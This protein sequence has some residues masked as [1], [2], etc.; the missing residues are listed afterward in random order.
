MTDPRRN[1]EIFLRSV[2]GFTDKQGAK[3]SH[4]RPIRLG[5]I[6]YDYVPE[7]FLGGINPRILFDGENTVSNKRYAVMAPYY[8]LAGD[9]V[10]LLPIGN[11]YL[12][13]GPVSSQAIPPDVQYYT[14]DG[15]WT[16]PAGARTI[17]V[18]V[19]AAGGGGGGCPNAGSGEGAV[20]GG[21]GGGGYA[22]SWLTAN[23]VS[24]SEAV[25]VGTGGA[26]GTGADDG[27]AGSSSSFGSHVSAN[28]GGGGTQGTA[29]STR[30][31]RAGGSG[32]TGSAG[33]L[34]IQGGDGFNGYTHGGEITYS[35]AGG[36]SQLAHNRRGTAVSGSSANG[37]AGYTHGGGGGGGVARNNSGTSNGGSGA[38]GIVIV[39]T[40]F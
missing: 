39:T 6:D 17:Y 23:T 13:I 15:T 8:P 38:D 21:G 37:T 26:G 30:F 32:G 5:A 27:S 7:E 3:R 11:S 10:C 18:Q 2:A 29:S 33:D 36:D 28:G 16:K 22:E 31:A 14:A 9:R 4:N 34:L 35:A 20:A 12:I 19:Q 25:T 1:A 24:S 40:F